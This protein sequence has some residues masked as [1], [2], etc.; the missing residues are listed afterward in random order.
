[1]PV[2]EK[3]PLLLLAWLCLLYKKTQQAKAFTVFKREEI[4]YVS[5]LPLHCITP[6]LALSFALQL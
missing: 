6:T 2:K 5:D 1:M 4:P 3:D